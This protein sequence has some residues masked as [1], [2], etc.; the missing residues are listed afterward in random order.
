MGGGLVQIER[1]QHQIN[2]S[3]LFMMRCFSSANL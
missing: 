3:I 2:G 1:I